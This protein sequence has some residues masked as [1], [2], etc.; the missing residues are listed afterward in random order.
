MSREGG[1]YQ[2]AAAELYRVFP[3]N[4]NRNA[5]IERLATPEGNGRTA[6]L[7]AQLEG[8]SGELEQVKSERDDLR[9]RLDSEAEERRKLT[10]LLTDQT[11]KP[12]A[13]PPEP[14]PKPARP[15]G[16]RGF[17]YRLAGAG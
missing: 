3:A 16:L 13:A 6:V 8:L 12:A 17:L 2:I 1:E 11:R 10:A 9:R 15:N 14:E 7:Q 4:S 5:E